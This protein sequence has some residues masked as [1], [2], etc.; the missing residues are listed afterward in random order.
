MPLVSHPENVGR[1]VAAW[2][3]REALS[4]TTL[5]ARSPTAEVVAYRAHAV[6]LAAR[7]EFMRAAV[8]GPYRD[9]R[10][11][12]LEE[13][14]PGRVEAL[15]RWMY[16]GEAELD[17]GNALD[18]FV[19]GDLR[20][21]C[22]AYLVSTLEVGHAAELLAAARSYGFEELACAAKAWLLAHGL[23][24]FGS[25]AVAEASKEVLLELLESEDLACPE[26]EVVGV[27]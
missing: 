21:E 7:S 12:L 4:D 10:D 16:A 1:D 19:V 20:A 22:E 2:L 3:Q 26:L 6:I 25:A 11:L 27:L 15:L 14:T 9:S 17:E 23:A 5:R 13:V 18:R 24:F 8:T